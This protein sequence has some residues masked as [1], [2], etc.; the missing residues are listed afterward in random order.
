[1]SLEYY[2]CDI[3]F[4]HRDAEREEMDVR[5]REI[6]EAWDS[7]TVPAHAPA[8]LCVIPI[9]MTEAWLLFDE[10]AIRRSAGNPNGKKE[11]VLPKRQIW[12]ALPDPKENLYQLLRLAR[13]GSRRKSKQF[14]PSTVVHRIPDLVSDL[15]T[16][17]RV[18]GL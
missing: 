2:R 12:E 10:M 18:E 3:L 16:T 14:S 4:V 5:R 13:E 1:M 8:Y 7:V 6:R 11:L 9:R 17:T 15:R